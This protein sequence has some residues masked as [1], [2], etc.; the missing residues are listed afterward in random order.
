MLRTHWMTSASAAKA[1]VRA[2]DYHAA[3]PGQWVGGLREPLGLGGQST[4]EQFDALADNRHPLTGD[5]LR[6]LARDNGRI[7]LDMTFNSSKSVGIAREMAGLDNAGDPRIETAHNEAVAYAMSFVEKDMRARVRVGGENTDRITGNMIAHLQTHRDTRILAEDQ[8]PD[9]SLHT[10]AFVFNL[11]HDPVEGKWKAAEMGQIKH[12]APYYEA[13]YHNRL[14]SN[15]RQ[16]GYGVRKKDKAFEIE[17]IT[18]DLVRKYSRRRA[19]ID[20][21]AEKLGITSPEGRNTLG[22]TTR[23]GKVKERADDLNRYWVSRLTDAERQQLT[24]L[25]GKAG[26]EGDA[27]AAVEFAIGHEFYYRSVAGEKR[28]YETALRMGIGGVTVDGVRTEAQRQGLLTKDGEATTREVLAEEGRV[29]GFAR[30][31][32]GTCRPMGIVVDQSSMTGLSAEQSAMVKHVLRSTDRMILV[33]GDAGTGKTRSIKAAFQQINRPIDMMATSANASRGVLRE[34]GFHKA[35]TVASFLIS[36]KRQEAVKDGVIWVDE[37]GQLPIRD[38]LQLID[39]AEAQNARIVMQGDPKQHRAVTR[40][41]NM[42][43]VL[44]SYGGLPVGRLT[45]IWRQTYKPYKAAVA[46]L[47]KGDLLGGYDQLEAL[48]WVREA[49]DKAPLVEDYLA[50][51]DSRKSVLIVAPTH[52]EGG[53]ITAEIRARLK[54][55]GTIVR[56]GKQV[57]VLVPLHWTEAERGDLERYEG[58]E[59]LQF[60]RNSGTFKAGD[61]VRVI[62]WKPGDRFAKPS[63]FAVYTSSSIE[64]AAG[65]KIRFTSNGK[66]KDGKHKINNGAIY[67]MKGF[68]KDEDIVLENGWVVAKDFGHLTHGYVT[69]SHASQGKTVDRVLIAMGHESRP[70]MGAEQFY[71]SVSRGRDQAT[72]YSDLSPVELREA[73]QKA[74]PRKSATE[75]LRLAP[76]PVKPKRRVK[77]LAERM[78]SAFQQLREKASAAMSVTRERERGRIYGGHTR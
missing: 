40:D 56:E 18:D 31:G 33:I 55:R 21:V 34:E 19:Y 14:A 48:G 1:Y 73:I 46:S 5:L 30:D 22:A 59:V 75:L 3:S 32:R 2:A 57:G 60:H 24:G 58:G 28:V 68:T 37:A 6:P 26:Y 23:L 67:P 43:N 54:E 71:V 62:D 41:G 66:T 78:R 76:V 50:A 25:I 61:R 70:A 4:F 45:E 29:I 52:A 64:L 12:D 8:L 9:M 44:Q 16:L 42:M 69:T 10:H 47:A 15:L 36:K 49:Q 74:D 7:G 35:D 39:I 53:E 63:H 13:I 38:L 51:L 77:T 20:Q 65:D 11:T 72:I 27:K 17:G